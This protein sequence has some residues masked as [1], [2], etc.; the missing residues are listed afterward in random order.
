M[1]TAPTLDASEA[2]RRI[3]AMAKP[4][5]APPPAEQ[6]PP[7]S[8]DFMQ[9]IEPHRWKKDATRKRRLPVM[10]W[11]STTQCRRG[12]I[13]VIS[14]KSGVGKT[15]FLGASV[16]SMIATAPDGTDLLGWGSNTDQRGAI[17]LI[18]LE[19]SDDDFDDC[20]QRI[21]RRAK[22]DEQPSNLYAYRLR[23]LTL[24][25]RQRAVSEILHKARNECGQV[26][27]LILDGGSDLIADTNSSEEAPKAVGDWLRTS[28]EHDCHVM[29]VV[30]LNE[31]NQAG[32]DPRGWLG[33]EAL[34][35][36][37]AAFVLESGATGTCVYNTK[38]RR[39][40]VS[41]SESFGFA[42]NDELKMH[43]SAM[44]ESK[45]DRALSESIQTVQ[46][47][48]ADAGGASLSY[49][50]LVQRIRNA[51][52]IGESAAKKRIAKL[53]SQKVLAVNSS[54]GMYRIEQPAPENMEAKQ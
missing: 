48:F 13:S 20:V 18:D 19:Q 17:I 39:A 15:A 9:R 29:I 43:T 12:N 53:K 26:D 22:T 11:R 41:K 7:A 46:A 5:P 38:T 32:V 24:A 6:P 51:E 33:K 10:T 3:A 35:K 14:A 44:V 27:L 50:D 34:R 47:I 21:L 4:P 49:T 31:S 16:A 52:N 8:D 37:E 42:W 23:D 28:T 25:E 2:L 45:A 1:S 30:H 36:C 54:T 40:G